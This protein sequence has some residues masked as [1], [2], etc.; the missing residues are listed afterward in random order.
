MSAKKAMKPMV[1]DVAA[2]GKL[3]EAVKQ[4]RRDTAAIG[5]LL[6]ALGNRDGGVRP[7][8]LVG[9]WALRWVPTAAA[10]DAIGTGLHSMPGTSFEDLFLSIGTEKSRKVEANEVL[11]VWGPFP[12]VRNVLSGSYAFDPSKGRL[13]ITFSEMVD[14]LGNRLA[15]KDGSTERA[16]DLAVRYVGPQVMI[17]AVGNEALVFEKVQSVREELIRLRVLKPKA[18]GDE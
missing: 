4:A 13:R 18:D 5:S 12:S 2:E 8:S 16:V 9:G 1:V 14:G 6:D 11:R 15:A 3:L 10:L 7:E 17:A